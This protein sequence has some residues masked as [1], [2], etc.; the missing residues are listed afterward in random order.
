MSVRL[1]AI[2]ALSLASCGLI[3]S[4]PDKP[5]PQPGSF[6]Y[7]LS[8]STAIGTVKTWVTYTVTA[9]A[10]PVANEQAVKY[11]INAPIA[12][13]KSSVST[14]FESSTVTF[15]IP[16]GLAVDAVS[17]DPITTPDFTSA[18]AHVDGQTI[19]FNL[20]GSFKFDSTTR[21]V[22]SVN[23]SGRIVAR[24]GQTVTW[25]AP[26]H[27]VGKANAGFFGDQTSDCHFENDGPIWV[28]HVD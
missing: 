28:S 14:T 26:I 7:E 16:E 18:E 10:E 20:T 12:Q 13:V 8:C 19:V 17:T 15:A 2:A 9:S 24:S 22:P 27:V 1:L 6:T 21:P 25:L 5:A 4:E 23:V 3:T 11:A